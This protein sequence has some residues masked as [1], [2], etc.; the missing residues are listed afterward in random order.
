M[1]PNLYIL[2]P[3]LN[4]LLLGM[5]HNILGLHQFLLQLIRKPLL[6]LNLT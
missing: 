5:I 2:H 4:I 1:I 6:L 3:Q